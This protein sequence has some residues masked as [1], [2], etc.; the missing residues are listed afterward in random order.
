MVNESSFKDIITHRVKDK[1]KILEAMKI[2]DEL[3]RETDTKDST[4]IIREWRKAR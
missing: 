2:Q 4:E 1:E 3:R